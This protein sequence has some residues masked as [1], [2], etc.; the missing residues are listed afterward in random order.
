MVNNKIYYIK[1]IDF[2]LGAPAR[3]L[4][5]GLS[6]HSPRQPRKL[7]CLRAIRCNPW[8][9]AI[10]APISGIVLVQ[11]IVE[12]DGTITNAKVIVPLYPSFDKEVLRVINRMPKWKPGTNMGKPVRCHYLLPI[13]FSYE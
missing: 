7:A 9:E 10:H 4:A 2:F 13:R 8:R 12:K 5:V 11:F 3:K 1:D 6:A